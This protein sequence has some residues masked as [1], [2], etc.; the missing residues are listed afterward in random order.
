MATVLT[1]IAAKTKLFKGFVNI[2]DSVS[3]RV[4][5]IWELNT[6]TAT[7]TLERLV[8]LKIHGGWRIA[9][10]LSYDN[11]D[12]NTFLLRVYDVKKELH[13]IYMERAIP[14]HKGSITLVLI[15][16][17]LHGV[18]DKTNTLR[19]TDGLTSSSIS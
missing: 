2:W 11:D 15:R 10:R 8:V 19:L 12:I 17:N 13:Y 1:K 18:P 16:L 3:S 6:V 7:V 14:L 5:S 9:P 4:G